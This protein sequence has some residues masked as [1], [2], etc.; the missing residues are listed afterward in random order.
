MLSGLNEVYGPKTTRPVN[1]NQ[2][3]EMLWIGLGQAGL[4]IGF[5]G[6][7]MGLLTGFYRGIDFGYI[8]CK[9]Q[10]IEQK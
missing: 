6:F 8:N 5:L 2:N 10:N 3:S 7:T 4:G 1:N 9:M